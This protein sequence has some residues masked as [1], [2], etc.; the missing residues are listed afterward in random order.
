MERMRQLEVLLQQERE[1]LRRQRA[2]L[3]T[4]SAVSKSAASADK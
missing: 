2:A 4:S 1:S 3:G